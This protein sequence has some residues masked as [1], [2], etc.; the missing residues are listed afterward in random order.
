[1]TINK[2]ASTVFESFEDTDIILTIVARSGS[3]V[4]NKINVFEEVFSEPNLL[5]ELC[6]RIDDGCEP[7]ISRIGGYLIAASSVNDTGYAI[8][9]LPNFD[10][11][12]NCMSLIEVILSQISLLSAK[13][14]TDSQESRFT[15]N[16]E[17]LAGV[18]LN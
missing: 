10:E 17:L 4:S 1:M 15:Y 11:S 7:L 8:M 3:Y 2:I 16:S 13:L 18:P 14:V 9:L 5:E 12:V 6:R